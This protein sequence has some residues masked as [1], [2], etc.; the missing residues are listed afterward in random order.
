ME[1]QE[2]SPYLPVARVAHEVQR[3]VEAANGDH[4]TPIWEALT[5][6][7][8]S[9]AIARAQSYIDSPDMTPV[10]AIGPTTYAMAASERSGAY[11]FYGAVRAIAHEQ[12]RE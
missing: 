11:A 8:Q 2:S 9:T 3:T 7:Q 4:R 12:T 10:T 1:T 5:Q 6:S